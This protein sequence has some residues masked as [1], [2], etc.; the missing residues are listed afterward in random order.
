[1][2][3]K[4]KVKMIRHETPSKQLDVSLR[5]QV[6]KALKKGFSILCIPKDVP[7]FDASGH[8]MLKYVGDI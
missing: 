1:M 6:G 2:G 4:K 5:N 8:H 3:P 7:A